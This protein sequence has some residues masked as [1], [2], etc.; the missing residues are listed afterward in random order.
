[1]AKMYYLFS[2]TLKNNFV[3]ALYLCDDGESIENAIMQTGVYPMGSFLS[4]VFKILDPLAKKN[5]NLYK[6]DEIISK[7]M[8]RFS[9]K[10]SYF[11]NLIYDDD[12]AYK[13]FDMLL[14]K[15]EYL[16]AKRDDEVLIKMLQRYWNYIKLCEKDDDDKKFSSSQKF[17]L[18]LN[19][20]Q[21]K[22]PEHFTYANELSKQ[23][24][25][26][27][28][29]I[30]NILAV[31]DLADSNFAPP[32]KIR[33]RKRLFKDI[34]LPEHE[35]K[36]TKWGELK[37]PLEVF[38]ITDVIDLVLASVY[39]I[40][41]QKFLLKECPYC[42]SLFITHDGKR[43]YCPNLNDE[44][45]GCYDILKLKRQLERENYEIPRMEKSLRTMYANKYGVDK[46][47]A[48]EYGAD[49][50]GKKYN[51]YQKLL[52]EMQGWRDRI[53]TGDDTNENYAVWLK[54]M[55]FKKYKD[56]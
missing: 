37:T 19:K 32:L 14:I 44:Y 12:S 23:S 45:K 30:E 31:D 35:I 29:E 38:V 40:F 55:Y 16:Q 25:L 1:M 5:F 15:R 4:K 18:L 49:K 34:D 13:M 33:V 2:E 24:I 6:W 42:K 17:S 54:S 11:S 56:K 47:G 20:A 51:K 27:E 36:K 48:D 41:Q 39:C 8:E 43:K 9:E 22:V 3:E 52:D 7:E 46:Y 26:T 10:N 53:K 21:D 28:N 50:H